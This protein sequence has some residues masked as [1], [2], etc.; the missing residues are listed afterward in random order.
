MSEKDR[1]INDIVNLAHCRPFY[2]HR[3]EHGKLHSVVC[4]CG[5]FVDIKGNVDYDEAYKRLLAKKETKYSSYIVKH[6]EYC[7]Y[8]RAV[9]YISM[10]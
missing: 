6:Y 1:I 3:N 7:I 2:D 9:E 5:Y 4:T 10:L 8:R